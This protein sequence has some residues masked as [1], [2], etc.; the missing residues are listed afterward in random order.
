M[1]V[2][3]CLVYKIYEAVAF[4][5]SS[6]SRLIG[7][8][9]MPGSNCLSLKDDDFKFLGIHLKN[10]S[11]GIFR[12]SIFI[13][14]SVWY[15]RSRWIIS[16]QLTRDETVNSKFL[17][18]PAY[19]DFLRVLVVYSVIIGVISASSDSLAH[20]PVSFAFFVGTF[21]FFYDGLWFFFVQYGAGFKAMLRACIFGFI[22]FIVTFCVFF[23]TAVYLR[24]DEE[25]GWF[26]L[27]MAYNGAYMLLFALPLCLPVDVLYR[28]PAIY[29]YSAVNMLYHFMACVFIMLLYLDVN[30]GYCVAAGLYVGFDSIIKP[31]VV[32]QALCADSEVFFL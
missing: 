31:I 13:L 25:D 2:L 22:S 14:I 23:K 12:L 27:M 11:I 30:A 17:L 19:F 20:R 4:R 10:F 3:C 29:A 1:C 8:A 21:H 7:I 26:S 28:R 16:K 5:V 24:D 15:L 9:I 18:L 6:S 32:Y